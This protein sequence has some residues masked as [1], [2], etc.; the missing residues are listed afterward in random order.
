LNPEKE[1]AAN[2]PYD[3]AVRFARLYGGKIETC[4]RV[5]IYSLGD[6][7]IWYTPGV[8]EISR[9]IEK[10]PDLSFDFTNRWNTVAIVTDGT[11]VL[12]LGDVGPEASLPVMEG[13]AL[14]FKYLGGVDALPL[15]LACSDPDDII[16]TV[17]RLEPAVGGINLEDI[18]HPKCFRILETLRKEMGIP[19]WHDD[20]QG[21]AAATVAG[22]LNAVKL[23]GR[24]IEDTEIAFVGAGAAN[25]ANA[26]LAEV[27]GFDPA[28]FIVVD[29]KGILHPARED[30]EKLPS[31]NPWKYE[32]AQKTNQE[33][34]T[35]DTKKALEGVDV[36]VA[37]SRPGPGTVKKDWIAQMAR[38]AI[39]FAL[40][41]PVPEIWPWEAK[42]AGARI[43]ATGRAD[44]PN[45][46]NNSL[47]FPSVFRG[48]LDVRAKTITD[49][50]AGTA[51]FE[52]ARHAEDV[53]LRE[54]YILPKMTEWEVYTKVAVATGRKAIKDGVARRNLSRDELT[55]RANEM[56]LHSRNQLEAL[57]D[58]GVIPSPPGGVLD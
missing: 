44:F 16:E 47:V 27:A 52:L 6:F 29:S 46:V 21:T 4:P 19:V 24:S 28:N 13:K 48:V 53:G 10:D 51:A 36:M 58:K 5:P 55:F 42:E 23:T 37:A 57:L 9:R 18:S 41:N 20:Q 33:G 34:R 2:R 50:M 35:G 25:V 38:D 17:K 45:Q 14:L 7:A 32:L 40:A 8:A 26:R 11:R 49:E 39:V 43:V 56:I 15:P 54:E 31:T 30:M 12:G 1:K 3:L 22:L